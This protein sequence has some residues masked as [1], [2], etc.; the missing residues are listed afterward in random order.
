MAVRVDRRITS[1]RRVAGDRRKVSRLN[2]SVENGDRRA[3][4]RGD[5]AVYLI[6]TDL[7]QRPLSRVRR[8]VRR[9]LGVACAVAVDGLDARIGGEIGDRLGRRSWVLHDVQAQR[10]D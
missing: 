2:S 3:T 10:G 6:P 1:D 9:R 5:G 8:I 7:R 4:T